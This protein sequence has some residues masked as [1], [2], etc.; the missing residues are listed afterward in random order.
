MTRHVANVD[1][2]V[3]VSDGG[4]GAIGFQVLGYGFGLLGRGCVV[5]DNCVGDGE[6]E[7]EI[8]DVAGVGFE[9]VQALVEF[10]V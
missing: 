9:L 2:A 1:E 6:V 10:F 7:G 8:F 5:N 3:L 4:V